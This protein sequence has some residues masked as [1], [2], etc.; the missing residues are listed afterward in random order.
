MCVLVQLSLL[1][2]FPKKGREIEVTNDLN[3]RKNERRNLGKEINGLI[4]FHL[5]QSR[6]VINTGASSYDKRF[7]IIRNFEKSC[8]T[9]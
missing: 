1:F 6:S 3:T 2:F 8:G 7:V 9:Y 5:T 4:C